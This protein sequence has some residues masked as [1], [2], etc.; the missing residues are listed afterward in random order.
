M[1]YYQPMTRQQELYYNF[2]RTN[3]RGA[4]MLPFVDSR[5]QHYLA[6]Y[7]FLTGFHRHLHPFSFL[8]PGYNV[9]IV[10]VH[11]GFIE[12]G[13]SMPYITASLVGE[14]GHVTVID[15]DK[16]NIEAVKAY[17][18]SQQNAPAIN[19]I[20]KGIWD[21]KGEQEFLF[22][23]DFTSSNMAVS[24][25]ESRIEKLERKWGSDRV[26]E[27]TFREVI[28]VDR[29]DSII[30]EYRIETPVN[31]LNVAVNGV[32]LQVIRSAGAL[33]DSEELEVI[34]F[35]YRYTTFD[36]ADF[37]TEKGFKIAVA[38]GNTKSWDDTPFHFACAVRCSEQELLARGFKPAETTRTNTDWGFDVNFL[39]EE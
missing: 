16:R 21:E 12:L 39:A 38:E 29:L 3:G 14:S 9:A 28:P 8:K 37:L 25:A 24:A 34:T 19:T 10:G 5:D 18:A 6:H 1:I 26:D 7:D 13:Y 2:H 33:L 27:N 17:S 31:Y 15:I 36:V 32:E 11:D 23:N 35:P 4:S 20:H 30:E 22:F